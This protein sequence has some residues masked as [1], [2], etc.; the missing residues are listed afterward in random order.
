MSELK[1]IRNILNHN[2]EFQ[3]GSFMFLRYYNPTQ[4]FNNPSDRFAF[5]DAL[6]DGLSYGFTNN[7]YTIIKKSNT[8]IFNSNENTTKPNNL[9]NPESINNLDN[10]NNIDNQYKSLYND[11]LECKTDTNNKIYF[12]EQYKN[13]QNLV[14]IKSIYIDI[15]KYNVI[16]TYI[17]ET[18]KNKFYESVYKAFCKL[19]TKEI[20]TL[21]DLFYI[22]NG[23][24]EAETFVFNL[25]Y[26]MILLYCKTCSNQKFENNNAKHSVCNIFMNT[27]SYWKELSCLYTKKSFVLTKRTTLNNF[28]IYVIN[29]TDYITDGTV[30]TSFIKNNNVFNEYMFLYMYRLQCTH[31]TDSIKMQTTKNDD[32]DTHETIINKKYNYDVMDIITN[33]LKF[34]GKKYNFNNTIHNIIQ[35]VHNTTNISISL[36]IPIVHKYN[37]HFGLPQYETNN[38]SQLTNPDEQ[39][40]KFLLNNVINPNKRFMI[41]GFTHLKLKNFIDNIKI[42]SFDLNYANKYMKEYNCTNHNSVISTLYDIVYYTYL[43]NSLFV[44]RNKKYATTHLQPTYIKLWNVS[45]EYF[46]NISN[47]NNSF[48]ISNAI[49][50][51][52]EF[53]I[54]NKLVNEFIIEINDNNIKLSDFTNTIIE[55]FGKITPIYNKHSVDY[56]GNLDDITIN[57]ST[58]CSYQPWS[59]NFGSSEYKFDKVIPDSL[60]VIIDNHSMQL[61]DYQKENILWMNNI[62]NKVDNHN[63]Y[64][65]NYI[66]KF[67]MENNNTL[68]NNIF[69]FLK[70]IYNIELHILKINY[71]NLLKYGDIYEIDMT[72]LLYDKDLNLDSNYNITKKYYLT[73]EET[74]RIFNN[75]KSYENIEKL[76]EFLGYTHNLYFRGGFLCD[77]VGLGKTASIVTHCLHK[78]KSDNHLALP[79]IDNTI[80]S[81]E[82]IAFDFTDGNYYN[83]KRQWMFNNLIIVPTRLIKQWKF[84]IEKYSANM[85]YKPSITTFSSITDI[86]KF[87]KQNSVLINKKNPI[88]RPDFIIMSSNLLNNNNYFKYIIDKH[89]EYIKKQKTTNTQFNPIKDYAYD[90]GCYFDIFQIWWNRII[91]DE[92]HE[93]VLTGSKYSKYNIKK[94]DKEKSFVIIN[95]I[96]SNYKWGLSATPIEKNI[97]N[98][99]SYI[100]W[101]N[102]FIKILNN[103]IYTQYLDFK[104]IYNKFPTIKEL[105]YNYDRIDKNFRS[106]LL[107]KYGDLD[108]IYNFINIK[109]LGN[110]KSDPLNVNSINILSKQLLRFD[111]KFIFSIP[112]IDYFDNTFNNTEIHML[113]NNNNLDYYSGLTKTGS[114]LNDTNFPGLIYSAYTLF[115]TKNYSDL[116]KTFSKVT[117]SLVSKEIGIPIFT[118]EVKYI[119]L[120][121]V[122]RGIY[123]GIKHELGYANGVDYRNETNS[124][125]RRNIKRLFQVC[126]NILINEYIMNEI[127]KINEVITLEELNENM[128]K[129]SETKL[130][131]AIKD[132]EMCD[133]FINKFNKINYFLNYNLKLIKD[134]FSDYF[135]KT[136]INGNLCKTINRYIT[137]FNYTIK[138]M[139]QN[140]YNDYSRYIDS[141]DYNA[142]EEYLLVNLEFKT[143]MNTITNDFP[144]NDWDIVDKKMVIPNEAQKDIVLPLVENTI[145]TFNEI[146]KSM[147]INIVSTN[148]SSA[149]L[150]EMI[151]NKYQNMKSSLARNKEKSEKLDRDIKVYQN[152]IKLFE[153]DD[154][155]KEKTA[156]PCVI[157]LGDYEEDVE[158]VIT[159]CRHIVCGDC[160]QVLIKR[161]ST[162]P[163][164]ECRQP[165][166]QTKVN[167]TTYD[168]IINVDKSENKNEKSTDTEIQSDTQLESWEI[169]CLNKYGTKM[170]HLIKTLN[171]LFSEDKKDENNRVIIFSQ[172]DNMLNIIGKTLTEFNIKFCQ[173]K[174]NVHSINKNIDLFKRDESIR[175]IMLSSDKCNSGCN[176]TEAN[177]II[178]I[179]VINADKAKSKDIET[180]AI[181]RSVRLGQKR[182][183]KLIRFVTKNTIEEETFLS[184][185]YNIKDIQ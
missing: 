41:N 127:N 120:T 23:N 78:L 164:P 50:L 157:C 165:V 26:H 81:R 106:I 101:Q 97:Q 96:N 159:P 38:N 114:L 13:N 56:M 151:L 8:N 172:Y 134:K 169:Q 49:M 6:Y 59:N 20:I 171:E 109:H 180:Q 100:F 37:I 89:T 11:K 99:S 86:K 85:D 18:I 155:I 69:K 80:I 90:I 91:I 3:F 146:I 16:S 185:R 133:N 64:T 46:K 83:N 10:L 103:H 60:K 44:C 33:H 170:L 19:L 139:E 22:T 54:H 58:K 62:E 27:Y 39:F 87:D 147:L 32:N 124:Y 66:I 158:V 53:G 163:C 152:Q 92:V 177:H 94:S 148:K 144:L 145:N 129:T 72:I 28:N 1:N 73:K 178:M 183:V 138:R 57:K 34:E 118:E 162:Y 184:N 93:V 132:K 108:P 2:N 79:Y 36:N 111:N 88:H 42:N 95:M 104:P 161:Q 174:G 182:P 136:P 179:D 71:P 52:F 74:K 29:H 15:G 12:N 154:F 65:N 113:M 143:F 140:G 7:S 5:A 128:K 14:E 167:I 4:S 76:F 121:T 84:E 98:T 175:V 123:D 160:F 112:F 135:V 105:D 141:R 43:L 173:I 142:F 24:T 51:N 48:N 131:L 126:T 168:K 63:L 107:R 30:N 40:L 25:I 153:S 150:Y 149:M 61:F 166:N 110:F 122:E 67:I 17:T 45:E 68:K 125:Y 130:K 75:T 181:G 35:Y 102:D 21:Q 156:E 47:T 77:D 9:D 55:T 31:I 176:L 137:Q 70:D 115:T 116:S 82:P 117:K 119:N